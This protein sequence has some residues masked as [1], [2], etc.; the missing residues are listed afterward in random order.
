[1][2]KLKFNPDLFL[3]VVELEKFR[4]FLDDEGFRKNI[5]EGSS[6]FGLIRNQILDL[7]F[8]NA[9]VSLDSIS[10]RTVK[11]NNV[12]A[13]DSLGNFLRTEENI[14]MPI[15]SDNQWY[16]IKIRHKFSNQEK[17]KVSLAINGD[18]IGSGTD[19]TK[20]LRGF[21]N[22]PSR[23]AFIGSEHNTLEYDVLEVIDDEHATIVHPAVT[24][25]GIATFNIESGLSYSIVGTFTP[26]INVPTESKYPFQYDS[27]E[28]KLIKEEIS[29]TRPSYN[30]GLEFY[31]ARVRNFT[32]DIVIQD[33]RKDI[34][35]MNDSVEVTKMQDSLN[36]IVGIEYIKWS[37]LTTTMVQ[38]EVHVAWGMRS[39][40][41]S[42]DPSR[43]IIT[44]SGSSTGGIYKTVDN[45]SD[46]DFDRWRVYSYNGEYSIVTA[47]IKQGSAIN[48]FVDHLDVDNFS[49][50][51]GLS[52]NND[53][54]WI[55]V[56][57]D[58]EEIE[59]MFIAD[60]DVRNADKTFT[61]PINTLIARCDLEVY[62]NPKCLFNVKY[63]Y[64]SHKKY[65]EYAPIPT[66]TIGYYTEDSFTNQGVLKG[67]GERRRKPYNS[68]I[69][70]GFIELTINPDSYSLFVKKVYIGDSIGVN[71]VSDLVGSQNI[72][73]KVNVDKVYQYFSGST[74]LNNDLY[75]SLDENGATEGNSFKLHFN[76]TSLVLGA[77]KIF[78]VRDYPSSTQ[79]IKTI[80]QGDV[81][82]MYNREGGIVFDLVFKDR[83]EIAH[84]NYSK[85]QPFEIKMFD[86]NVTDYFNSSLE[87]KVRGYFGWKIH[88]IMQGRVPLGYGTES[89]GTSPR[90]F[91]MGAKG[92]AYEHKLTARQSGLPAH[93][94]NVPQEKNTEGSGWYGIE[95]T[96]Q[97]DAED[98]L[99]FNV[100]TSLSSALGAEESHNNIQ[101]YYVLA[102]VKKQY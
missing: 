56:V 9:Q 22:F 49:D 50:D 40:N 92:G 47:S 94:H 16:W 77:F 34:W 63:R 18:L 13:I 69:S 27:V 37:N 91:V 60:S 66:D 78:I 102:F 67:E 1:M 33:K 26:G 88:Q 4:E 12:R 35:R 97:T 70:L 7:N 86:G 62:R 24:G 85:G 31:V 21:P 93:R 8:T 30:E 76:Y 5:V 39:Q 42:I 65:T 38:N 79:I 80:D 14:T 75:I 19:F 84:Q 74:S 10:E 81:Y 15:P 55:V 48:L 11:M 68:N 29:N 72:V 64:K 83:W 87:G 99:E 89:D 20:S 6:N 96:D 71:K 3:E 41:W 28:V 54:E 100:K 44:L 57:P 52:F 32:T 59:L 61:F 58:A 51:G 90:T 17:G 53:S 36:S 45:F 82:E 43:N 2:S 25:T 98:K 95:T 23:I 73:L 46:G 101:P